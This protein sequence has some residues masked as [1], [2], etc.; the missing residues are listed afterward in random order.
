MEIARQALAEFAESEDEGGWEIERAVEAAR[1]RWRRILSETSNPGP[2]ERAR[3]MR[4]L[5]SRGFSSDA[6]REAADRVASPGAGD[7]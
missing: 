7:D 4:F 1:E 2:R 3:L 6:A 5:A